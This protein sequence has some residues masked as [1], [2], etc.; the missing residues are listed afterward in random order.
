MVMDMESGGSGGSRSGVA[1]NDGSTEL[2]K[3][4]RMFH[5]MS[6]AYAIFFPDNMY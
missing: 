4:L 2:G 1:A 5:H 6:Q 3:K